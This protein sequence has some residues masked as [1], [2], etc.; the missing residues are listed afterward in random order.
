MKDAS[1]HDERQLRRMLDCLDAARR[2]GV[3]LR[4]ASDSL[5]FLRGALED[6]DRGWADDFTSHVATLESASVASPS[7]VH[8][9]GEEYPRLVKAT[10]DALEALVRARLGG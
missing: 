10:L 7:Q 8:D 5:L 6:V 9:M 2:G 3:S 4:A 1:K